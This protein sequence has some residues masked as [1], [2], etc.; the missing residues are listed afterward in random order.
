MIWG[1]AQM[2]QSDYMV[3]QVTDMT[4]SK[5]FAPGTAFEI[6]IRSLGESGGRIHLPHGDISD[7][8]EYGYNSITS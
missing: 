7:F 3:S 8:G 4:G 2:Y 1:C 6:I 5:I